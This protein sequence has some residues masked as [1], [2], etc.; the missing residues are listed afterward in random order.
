MPHDEGEELPPGGEGRLYFEDETGRGVIYP[1][2][3]AKSK[4]AHLRPGVFTLGEIGYVDEDGFVFITDRFSDMIVSGGV[5]I[6]PAEA[7]QLIAL[8]EGVRDVVCIGIPHA[9]MGEQLHAL[10]E[11]V[12]KTSP[13]TEAEIL[14]FCRDGLS[15]YKCPRSVEFRGDIGRDAMGKIN[16]KQLRAPY[17]LEDLR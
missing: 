10:V 8:H 4:Q 12:D 16:K 9:E 15:H 13:P 1:K 3:A 17:W 11:P 6:Y 2:D 7:E 14:A 5:N